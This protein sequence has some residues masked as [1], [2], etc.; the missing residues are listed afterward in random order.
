MSK[1]KAKSG[2]AYEFIGASPAQGCPPGP[3]TQATYDAL[4]EQ[5][6]ERYVGKFYRKTTGAAAPPTAPEAPSETEE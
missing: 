5:H 2:G 1:A 4:C 6:G 3:I